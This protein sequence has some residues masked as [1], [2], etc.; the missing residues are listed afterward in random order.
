MPVCQVNETR[1][2]TQETEHTIPNKQVISAER[3]PLPP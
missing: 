2:E 3:N 1:K